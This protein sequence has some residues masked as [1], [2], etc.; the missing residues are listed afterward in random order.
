[1]NRSEDWK[2]VEDLT[3]RFALQFA[4]PLVLFRATDR[5]PQMATGILLQGEPAPLL[6]SAR[7]VLDQ[8]L[9]YGSE[10][11][12]QVGKNAF[13]GIPPERVNLGK[14][15]DLGSVALLP[16]MLSNFTSVLG[17]NQVARERPKED[18]LVAFVGYPGQLKRLTEE[19]N[20]MSIGQY[21]YS[22]YIE[23]TEHDQFSM[24]VETTHD[25]TINSLRPPG[26]VEGVTELGGI[27]GAPVFIVSDVPRLLGVVSEGTAWSIREHKIYAAPIHSLDRD[28]R[29]RD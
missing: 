4:L 1:M 7:H 22:G 23:T 20:G 11:R 8:L 21:V 15:V 19:A 9:K 5:T 3:V 10:G 6:V 18:M 25:F 28:G 12:L 16:S 27:S 14:S 29:I 17:W 13:R 2:R 24:R 26:S